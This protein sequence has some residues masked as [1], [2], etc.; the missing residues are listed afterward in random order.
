MNLYIIIVSWKYKTAFGLAVF[1]SFLGLIINSNNALSQQDTIDLTEFDIFNSEPNFISYSLD[2]QLNIYSYSLMMKMNYQT[3][4]GNLLINQ[5]YSGTSYS[6][7]TFIH[8]DDEDFHFIYDYPVYD[9]FSILSSGNAVII[10]NPGSIELNSLRRTNFLGGLR[11][12]LPYLF[13]VDFMAGFEDNSQIGILSGGTIYKVNG[14]LN[15]LDLSGYNLSGILTGELLL[16]N[17]DRVNRTFNLTTEVSKQFDMF[18]M[19]SIN[20]SYRI[21]DRYNAFKR[22]SEYMAANQLDFEYSLEARFNNVLLT[23]VSLTFGLSENLFGNFKLYFAQNNTQRFYKEFVSMD[24][25]TGIKQFREQIKFTLNPEI[26]FENDILKQITGISYSFDSDENT[27]ENIRNIDNNEFNLLKTRAY[28]LDNHTTN[29]RLLSK[30]GIKITKNDT[31]LLSGMSSITKYDT[32]SEF[33]NSDRDE[34]LG[35]LSFGYRRK[36]SEN[37]TLLL[38]FES[39]FNHQVNLKASRSASNFWMRSIKFAPSLVIQTKRFFMR[40]Q[41]YVLA[42]YTVYDFEGVA[43]GIKSFSL[44]QIGY[45]DSLSIIFTNNLYLGTRIDLIYKETGTLFW[46]DF[47]ESPVNGNLKLFYR[48]FT[49]YIDKKFNIAI[50]ARYFNLTQKNFRSSAFI[51]SDYKTESYAPEVSISAEFFDGATLKINGWYEFQIINDS[52]YNEIPN[53]ILNT[54]IRF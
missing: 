8:Q 35:L 12:R 43:P 24:N 47:K 27:V 6:A 21:L 20:L 52:F 42:N 30:T 16:L 44:R 40:P 15:E 22:D 46:S 19:L 7:Q 54:S 4:Y 31:L 26:I 14:I 50:G 33:N 38:D 9:D 3:V 51:N 5:K 17:L 10:N 32:P 49:G 28:E 1:F 39:H 29:F 34:F 11:Y 25:R 37:V 53:I 2:K 18:D 23:D 13:S 36:M 48:F 41:P 45:N